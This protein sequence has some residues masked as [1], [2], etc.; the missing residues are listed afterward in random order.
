MWTQLR[1]ALVSDHG[2]CS[3]CGLSCNMLAL[4]TSDCVQGSGAGGA[5]ASSLGSTEKTG[6]TPPPPVVVGGP[7]VGAGAGAVSP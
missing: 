2:P 6:A 1:R 5:G 7:P 3:K 4:I